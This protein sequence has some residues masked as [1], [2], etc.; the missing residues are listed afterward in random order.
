MSQAAA[1]GEVHRASRV[2]GAPDGDALAEAAGLT[3]GLDTVTVTVDDDRPAI[4]SID[5]GTAADWTLAALDPGP[6]LIG[7]VVLGH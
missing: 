3:A 4:V 5:G 2:P 1:S 7:A 6:D